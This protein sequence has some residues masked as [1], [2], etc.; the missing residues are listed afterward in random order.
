MKQITNLSPHLDQARI[1]Y[2]GE[3]VTIVWKHNLAAGALPSL[4]LTK[5]EKAAILP[6]AIRASKAVGIAFA[7]VDIVKTR[8][9]DYQVI[10]INSGIMME[11]FPVLIKDGGQ[12]S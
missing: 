1:L 2:Q 3:Q 8:K 5:E 11:K 12:N 6:L 9:G 10:E 4:S 7:S